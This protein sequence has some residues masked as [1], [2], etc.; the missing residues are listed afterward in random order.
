MRV[1]ELASFI[2]RRDA[3]RIAKENPEA[4][5]NITPPLHKRIDP[6]IQK[7]RF[8]NVRRE[9]D[10]VTKWIAANWREPYKDSPNL[11]FAMAAARLLNLPSSLAAIGFPVPWQPERVKEELHRRKAA[12]LKNFNAAYIVSTNGVPMDK[13]DYIV[14]FV[15]NPLWR[16]RVSISNALRGATLEQAHYLLE[17]QPGLGSFLAAQIVA[18][19]KYT[20]VLEQA[21]DWHTFAASGPGSRRGLNRV[22]DRDPNH[23]YGSEANWRRHLG[24]LREKL[25][26][27]LPPELQLHAQ[28]VQNC[29]CEFDKYERARLGEGRPKQLYKPYEEK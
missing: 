16:K 15:L 22:L 9:D 28:D 17:Q 26:R 14:D 21:E 4:F 24:E 6:I 25:L 7:Y 12:R 27:L 19:L 3:A 18:D 29:L 13:I 10:R 23:P 8:C 11:W 2:L 20:P 5:K 1:K